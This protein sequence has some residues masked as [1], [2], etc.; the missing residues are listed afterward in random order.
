MK[1]PLQLCCVADPGPNTYAAGPNVALSVAGCW[2]S[3]CD[4][5]NWIV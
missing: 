3:V 2:P 1:R 4:L 5:T